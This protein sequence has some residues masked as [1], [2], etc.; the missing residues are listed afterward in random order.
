M[1]LHWLRRCALACAVPLL[2]AIILVGS[3]AIVGCSDTS[4]SNRTE[5]EGTKN[6]R[7]AKIDKLKA[8]KPDPGT[9]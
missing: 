1:K 4:S 3:M 9:K 8:A 2:S 5:P 7:T 6:K